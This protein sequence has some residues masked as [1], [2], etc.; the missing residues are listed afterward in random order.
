MLENIDDQL[1]Q[2]PI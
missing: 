1:Q 2:L